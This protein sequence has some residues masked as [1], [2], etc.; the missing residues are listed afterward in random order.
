M[1]AAARPSNSST[2]KGSTSGSGMYWARRPAM[3]GPNP[4][5]AS[6]APALKLADV[7]WFSQSSATQAV[8]APAASGMP[9][10]LKSLPR[11]SIGM[12]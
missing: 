10:P 11:N 12:E 5:P 2:A 9:S 6:V 1:M 8:P 4:S 7:Q 3:S